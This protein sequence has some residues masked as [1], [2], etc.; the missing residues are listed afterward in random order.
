MDSN[1]KY[2]Q[3]LLLVLNFQGQKV[4]V[5]SWTDTSLNNIWQIIQFF[6]IEV[7]K[8]H[9]NILLYGEQKRVL[10]RFIYLCYS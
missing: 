5:N 8:L 1:M 6:D 3:L 7:W 10:V 9:K 2:T 4:E